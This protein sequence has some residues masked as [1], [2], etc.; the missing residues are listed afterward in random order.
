MSKVNS[1]VGPKS[2]SP[3]S[4]LETA[5]PGSPKNPP[6]T[7]KHTLKLQL[8]L[9]RLRPGSGLTWPGPA[10]RTQTR[11]LPCRLKKPCTIKLN[12]KL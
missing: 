8:K 3:S 4:H 5:K 2:L 6:Y 1:V 9:R 10:L 11:F 7:M 12:L